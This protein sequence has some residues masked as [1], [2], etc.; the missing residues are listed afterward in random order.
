MN[1]ERIFLNQ[2]KKFPCINVNGGWR[3]NGRKWLDFEFPSMSKNIFQISFKTP[4]WAYRNSNFNRKLLRKIYAKYCS[5]CCFVV[6]LVKFKTS[7]R[8]KCLFTIVFYIWSVRAPKLQGLL[9]KTLIYV[10]SPIIVAAVG[11]YIWNQKLVKNDSKSHNSL[12]IFHW[13]ERKP[14]YFF[15]IYHSNHRV[16]SLCTFLN[17]RPVSKTPVWFFFSNHE[18]RS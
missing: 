13:N 16:R 6:G 18:N 4:I 3:Y 14:F 15:Y 17:G 8:Q 12:Q 10:R 9:F 5:F 1:N 11:N 2:Q 7:V